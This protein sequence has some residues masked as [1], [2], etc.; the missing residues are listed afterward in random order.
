MGL[1]Y[2]NRLKLVLQIGRKHTELLILLFI[3]IF[4]FNVFKEINKSLINKES[5]RTT[6]W[7]GDGTKM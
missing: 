2:L 5:C 3:L 6:D 4:V 7:L 1:K